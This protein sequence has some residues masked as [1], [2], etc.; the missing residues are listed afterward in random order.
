[1]SDP[2]PRSRG[3]APANSNLTHREE[4]V[5][6]NPFSVEQLQAE[7]EGREKILRT[8][9]TEDAETTPDMITGLL[10]SDSV[11]QPDVQMPRGMRMPAGRAPSPPVTEVLRSRFFASGSAQQAFAQPGAA[12]LAGH[13]TP[14]QRADP[15]WPSAVLHPISVEAF[16]TEASR[17]AWEATA[18]MP[19]VRRS[20]WGL[21]PPAN[22]AAR[23]GNPSTMRAEAAPFGP[24]NPCAIRYS[25]ENQPSF[26]GSEDRHK[27]AGT[28]NVL[29]K[30]A[31]SAGPV[32]PVF[33]PTLI[34]SAGQ[35][36]ARS[37]PFRMPTQAGGVDQRG[38]RKLS[39]DGIPGKDA[40]RAC[41]DDDMHLRQVGPYTLPPSDTGPAASGRSEHASAPVHHRKDVKTVI[42]AFP[43]GA[44]IRLGTRGT[45]TMNITI[46][47]NAA[48]V[49]AISS[50]LDPGEFVL[51]TLP[52][53]EGRVEVFEN[54][55]QGYELARQAATMAASVA[56]GLAEKELVAA[57]AAAEAKEKGAS[58]KGAS[59][60]GASEKGA[61]TINAPKK[62]RQHRGGRK[63]NEARN[64][65]RAAARAQQLNGNDDEDIDISEEDNE[66]D[67]AFHRLSIASTS[68]IPWI[69]RPPS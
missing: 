8:P 5:I 50:V 25:S 66:D 6:S 22:T 59:E 52:E 42:K 30:N 28:D 18:A 67:R 40:K 11:Q 43:P 46:P 44:S 26:V 38:R 34:S 36:S 53:R 45:S 58:E 60:K 21:P 64:K 29:D 9:E 1:M 55:L 2:P 10:Y 51:M 35:F 20:R 37:V 48:L 69:V 33:D 7:T 19:E 3:P 16:G 17:A 65:K 23:A 54:M 49:N 14:A 24:F 62:K 13:K 63:A 39:G 4:D 27:G 41:M 15:V 61:E 32:K 57:Q 56:R 31:F 68:H 47:N 12:Q